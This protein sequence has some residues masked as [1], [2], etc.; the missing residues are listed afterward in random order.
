MH[1]V[2]RKATAQPNTTSP[3]RWRATSAP[4]ILDCS[5]TPEAM[6]RAAVAGASRQLDDNLTRSVQTRTV[7]VSA[8]GNTQTSGPATSKNV[9]PI[10][11]PM[12]VLTIRDMKANT[13][14]CICG[15]VATITEMTAQIAS[16][17]P[18]LRSSS[19]TAVVPMQILTA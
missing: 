9:S 4:L 19:Q 5:T 8:S 6:T 13:A 16:A 2:T 12:T 15:S 18:T 17:S 10:V 7:T 11:Q 14:V 3:A 1:Q